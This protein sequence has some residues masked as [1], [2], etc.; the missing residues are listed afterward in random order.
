MAVILSVESTDWQSF[1]KRSV[2]ELIASEWYWGRRMKGVVCWRPFI[3]DASKASSAFIGGT[4]SLMLRYV[5]MTQPNTSYCKSN[6]A[7]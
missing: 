5:T 6:S 3:Y 4:R 2:V 7:E 1:R